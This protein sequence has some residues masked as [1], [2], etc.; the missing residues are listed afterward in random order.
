M[1]MQAG[2]WL[3]DGAL[4][5]ARANRIQLDISHCHEPMVFDHYEKMK[6]LLLFIQVQQQ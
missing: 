1:T 3:P 5:E 2:R 4:A 6:A